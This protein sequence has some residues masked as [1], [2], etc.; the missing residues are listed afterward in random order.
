MRAADLPSLA[1]DTFRAYYE[2]LAAGTTGLIPEAAIEPIEPLPS[3]QD[4]VPHGAAG[5]SALGAT[6]V[7]KLN[8]GLGTGMGMQRAKSL[9]PVKGELSF[10]DVIAR[11]VGALRERAGARL[12]LVLMNSFATRDDS[13]AHLARYD[14]LSADLPADFLQHRVPRVRV[15]DLSPVE[16]PAD[17]EAEWCPP[18]HGDLYP[19]LVTSG[20]LERMLS[21][22]YHYAFVSN[23]D[24]LGAVL[25]PSILGFLVERELPFLMEV[26][27][28]T[29]A[30]R[31]GGHLAR[32]R[33]GGLLLRESAQCPDEDQ[34][35]FQDVGRHRYFNTNSLWVDLRAL[36]ERLEASGGVLGLPMIR[37]EKHV[38][39][40]DPATPR[41]YQLETAMGAALSVFPGAAALRVPRRRFAPVK[42]TSD[43]LV[44]R[45]DAYALDAGAELVPQCPPEALPRVTLDAGFKSVADFDARFPAGP[46]SLRACRTLRVEGDVV[47]G[48][49]VVVEG[50]VAVRAEPGETHR[51]PDGARLRG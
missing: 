38:V 1:I 15:D 19:A 24:N 32:E 37:N 36:A 43:L 10:L 35:A 30:D 25:D 3:S 6:V 29:E 11:Q 31:K 12:P 44:V 4:L 28:R 5:T 7:I 13:L 33:G 50:D 34:D 20:A 49:G 26:A 18:G 17:P 22:G 21:A 48:E 8:G 51:V 9:L 27:D 39:A 2:Q 14:A 16:W 23:S 41:V 47:F 40:S 46:P 45:S 42:A